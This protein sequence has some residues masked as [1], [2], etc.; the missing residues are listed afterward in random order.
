MQHER[1][2]CSWT[3][4]G[5]RSGGTTHDRESPYSW[6]QLEHRPYRKTGRPARLACARMARHHRRTGV[7]SMVPGEPRGHVCEGRHDPG[8]ITHP[9]DEHP[10][11]E[12][13]VDETDPHRAFYDRR[14]PQRCPR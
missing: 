14:V 7:W 13:L 6:S 3:D 5:P 8:G 11:M 2:T 12:G 1:C 10:T 9:G 4:Y